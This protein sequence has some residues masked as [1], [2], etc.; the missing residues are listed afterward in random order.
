MEQF[1]G[2]QAAFGKKIHKVP[3]EGLLEGFSQ[4]ESHFI[5]VSRNFMLDVLHK[6]TAKNCRNHQIQRSYKNIKVLI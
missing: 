4:L 5:A 2:S 6:K 3:T 1:S